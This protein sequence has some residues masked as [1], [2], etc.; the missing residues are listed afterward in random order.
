MDEARIGA[1]AVVGP[2]SRLRPGTEIGEAAIVVA[3]D[4]N[5]ELLRAVVAALA[6]RTPT[7]ERGG[8]MCIDF[9]RHSAAYAAPYDDV[10]NISRF[11]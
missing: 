7:G 11:F 5:A 6:E 9:Q 1:G 8:I 10:L 4:F 3:H 2:Y